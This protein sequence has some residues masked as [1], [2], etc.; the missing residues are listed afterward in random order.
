MT[1]LRKEYEAAVKALGVDAARLRASG[2]TAEELA[3]IL[4]ERRQL[5]VR[6]F[7]ERTP[8]PLRSA[9]RA[10]AISIYGDEKGPSIEYLLARGKSWDE[11]VVSACRVG[12]FPWK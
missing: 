1:K 8:E 6:T 3:R 10:R 9:I 4:H 11:I 5:L 7:R 12:A 2:A